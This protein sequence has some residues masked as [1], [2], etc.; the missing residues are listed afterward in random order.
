MFRQ[1]IAI[2]A[3]GAAVLLGA[4]SVG[5]TAVAGPALLAAHAKAKLH[6]GLAGLIGQDGSPVAPLTYSTGYVVNVRWDQLQS[7][8]NSALMASNP[9]DQAIA[10]VQ[11]WNAAN[12]NVQR[13]LRIRLFTSSNSPHDNTDA[14]PQSLGGAP[15]TV[16]EPAFNFSCEVGH[17]WTTAY[18]SA[19]A[20]LQVELAAKYDGNSVVREIVM[21]GAS[22]C[23]PE[24]FLRYSWTSLTAAGDTL[25]L[26]E[27]SFT[28]Q[29]TAY[30]VWK[31][32]LVDMTFNPYDAPGGGGLAFTLQ[33]MTAFRN[34]FGHQG[35]LM[36][37]SLRASY[38]TGT[39]DYQMMYAD[40][41]KDGAPIAFQVAV[42]SKMR[43]AA[44]TFNFACRLGA[45]SVEI[46][47]SAYTSTTI[48]PAVLQ[49]AQ[50]CLDAN[51]R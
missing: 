34:A 27:A 36:N 5:S 32:A 37:D 22:L 9:I 4:A 18:Q 6:V 2:L 43:D 1:R 48:S 19:L 31:H 12:P 14:W 8:P 50:Q 45:R 44:T 17:F 29:I 13:G 42:L 7:G 35:V 23:Y 47:S 46:L 33:E 20:S 25:A 15:V 26:D 51:R 38:A 28:Q 41:A 49:S 30:R 16:T 11:A 21:G 24:P 10:N 40:M 3:V 39:G